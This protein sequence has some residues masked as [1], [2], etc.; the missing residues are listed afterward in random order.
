M[1]KTCNDRREAEFGLGNWPSFP[2]SIYRSPCAG[3]GKRV[4]LFYKS[5]DN[6]DKRSEFARPQ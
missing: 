3:D 2:L 4:F 5:D 1:D 6:W